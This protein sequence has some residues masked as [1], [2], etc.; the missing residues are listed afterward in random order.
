[1]RN[2]INERNEKQSQSKNQKINK[3]KLPSINK[4]GNKI[5]VNQI[6][7]NLR[8]PQSANLSNKL[9]N[10]AIEIGKKIYNRN[11]ITPNLVDIYTILEKENKESII[12]PKNRN[13]NQ[14]YNNKSKFNIEIKNK[15]NSYTNRPSINI[16]GT[17]RRK[18]NNEL[19]LIRNELPIKAKEQLYYLNNNNTNKYLNLNLKNNNKLYKNSDDNNLNQI[20]YF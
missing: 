4:N 11:I 17:D 15:F 9:L 6:N 3:I 16:I 19:Q 14:V 2:K 7:N 18:N 5:D 1:M 8:N 12:N 10:N 13:K 20:N